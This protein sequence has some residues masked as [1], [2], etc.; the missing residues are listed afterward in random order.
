M[1]YSYTQISQYVTCPRRYRYRYLDG[2]QEKD[3]RAAMLFGRAFERAIAALF[4]GEDPAATLFEQWVTCKDAV[5]VDSRPATWD[6]MLQQG[7]QLLECIIQT[8]PVQIREP[9]SRQQVQFSR[10]LSNGNSFVAFVD[11]IGEL[12]GTPWRAGVEDISARYPEEPAGIAALDPQL[13]CYSWMTGSMP[14]PR[15]SSSASAP[16]KCSTWGDD[17]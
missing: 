6:S 16:S 12:D 3:L 7:V 10:S 9:R 5:L 13:I 11:A 17:H 8:G 4:R 15:S 14:L 2:W 1:T